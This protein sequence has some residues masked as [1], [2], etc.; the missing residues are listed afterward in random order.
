M[1]LTIVNEGNRERREKKVL[2]RRIQRYEN[3]EIAVCEED[4]RVGLG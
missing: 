3:E 2:R 1:L 4:G